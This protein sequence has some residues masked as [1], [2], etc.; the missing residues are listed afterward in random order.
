MTCGDDT[1][2]LHE[3]ESIYIPQGTIHRLANLQAE[4]L[5]VIEVQTGAYLGEDDIERFE[6]D[7]GR[8]PNGAG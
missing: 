1:R 5:E 4:V 2:Q 6:D 3:N 7:F 8:A